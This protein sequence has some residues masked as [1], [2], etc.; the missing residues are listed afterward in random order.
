MAT[1][2][3]KAYNKRMRKRFFHPSLSDVLKRQTRT[4]KER[5]KERNNFKLPDYLC[6]HETELTYESF[7][8]EEYP[9]FYFYGSPGD[10]PSII[11]RYFLKPINTEG[12]FYLAD[13]LNRIITFK[14]IRNYPKGLWDVNRF[15][16]P[17]KLSKYYFRKRLKDPFL[18]INGLVYSIKFVNFKSNKTKQVLLKLI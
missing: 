13:F 7:L 9:E 4:V 2:S 6:D 8:I 14:P 11:K 1:I 10:T 17:V 3:K 18:T 5:K 12:E 15:S 16:N